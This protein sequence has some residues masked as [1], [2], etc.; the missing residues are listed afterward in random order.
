[1]GKNICKVGIYGAGDGASLLIPVIHNTGVSEVIIVVDKNENAPGLKVAMQH[2]IETVISSNCE[3]I[4]Q[5]DVDVIFNTTGDENCNDEILKAIA[6]KE[7][8][9]GKKPVLTEGLEAKLIWELINQKQT[10]IDQQKFLDD[11]FKFDTQ[12]LAYDRPRDAA[13]QI[14]EKALRLTNTVKGNLLCFDE[15]S[16]ELNSL[17]SKGYN[18]KFNHNNW[19][20]TDKGIIPKIIHEKQIVIVSNIQE[21]EEYISEV[22]QVENIQSFIAVPILVET[23]KLV[24][25]LILNDIQPRTFSKVELSNLSL[26]TTH[27]A[28]ILNKD[29]LVTRLNKKRECL[30]AINKVADVTGKSLNMR[31]IAAK[32]LEK[33]LEVLNYDLGVV[34]K[35]NGDSLEL[36]ASKEI[37]PHYIIKH[38]IININDMVKDSKRLKEG[39]V[40]CV[41]DAVKEMKNGKV[42]SSYIKGEGAKSFVI[43]PLMSA[44]RIVGVM[45]LGN[46]HITTFENNDKETLTSIGNVIGVAI[47]NA[48]FHE[49][50]EQKFSRIE[51]LKGIRGTPGDLIIITDM[52]KKIQEFSESAEY[53]LEYKRNEIIGKC[54]CTF[55]ESRNDEYEISELLKENN[56]VQNFYTTFLKSNSAPVEVSLSQSYMENSER[57]NIGIVSVVRDISDTNRINRQIIQSEKLSSIGILA[58]GIAHE[59]KNPL[60]V[61]K[62]QVGFLQKSVDDTKSYERID[63]ILRNIKRMKA[64]IDH[65]QGFSRESELEL[66]PIA[67]GEVINDSFTLLKL[68]LV[69]NNIEVDIEKESNLPKI[70]GDRVKL[71]QIFLNMILNAQD[72]ICANVDKQKEKKITIKII[73]KDNKI[74]VTFS[75]TGIG[76]SEKDI[77][78]IFVPF[79]TNKEIGKG[80]GLGLSIG[81][82]IIEK[83][84]G[85]IAVKSEVG[86]GATFIVQFTKLAV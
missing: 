9:K 54:I 20:A 60:S 64:I 5:R 24:G 85:S 40:I 48:K 55:F 81:Y 65:I 17:Y 34:R 79:F 2:K 83:H 30:E 1:M 18:R 12:I 35:F 29:M 43:V 38:N 57:E 76:I 73:K 13:K 27:S 14:V 21:S 42:S 19:K 74:V 80:T 51:I 61:V 82:D 16:K 62:T 53:L 26:L 70:L 36:L 84:E 7:F 58:S 6:Q 32:G 33:V 11:L 50:L 31:E 69:N 63:M 39:N 72:A 45:N 3:S 68:Q 75:D 66:L 71:E 23:N 46:R 15:E 47:E 78:K 41:S 59:L 10:I 67:I 8:R 56:C 77:E 49:S 86:K 22:T 52:E 44:D 28:Y 25:L 37:S 4:L